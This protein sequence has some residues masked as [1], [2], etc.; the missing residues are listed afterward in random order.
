[1][2]KVQ[3]RKP[4]EMGVLPVF[5]VDSKSII[6]KDEDGRDVIRDVPVLSSSDTSLRQCNTC[7]VASNCP[8]F[9]VDSMC[10]FKLPV[11]VK[12]KDQLKALINT[13]IEMQ[14]Q[15]AAFA[16]FSEELAGGYPDPNVGQEIDRL[17][18]ILKTVKELDDSQSFIKM[19]IEGRSSGAGVL[20]NIFG[21]KA[22]VLRELPETIDA[23]I[24]DEVIEDHLGDDRPS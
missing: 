13:V 14:V 22:Q 1:M 16:R 10:A 4:E 21:E 8:A 17:L 24:V 6:D 12:T 5:G 18:K 3:P 20:S 15:R 23:T 7:F 2:R 11:E 9:K 19:T